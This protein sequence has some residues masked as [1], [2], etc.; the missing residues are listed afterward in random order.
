MNETDKTIPC[1]DLGITGYNPA[2]ELQQKIFEM[3][4]SGKFKGAILLLEHNPVITIG[5]NRNQENILSDKETL[6]RQG[7]ELIQSNRGGDVTFHGPGQLICYPVFDLNHF[8]KDV[9]NFVYNLEQVVIDVLADYKIKGTRIEKLRGVFVGSGKIASIG[10]HVKKWIT[11]HGFSFNVNVD[12]GYFN[13]IIACGLKDYL[14][15]SLE[16]LLTKPVSVSDVKELVIQK[17]E[18][19]FSIEVEERPATFLDHLS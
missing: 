19:I 18:K 11:Y 17:F 8:G 13:N 2:W 5:N 12:L 10:I 14:P 1:F 15:V 6:N 7:I 16:K 3:V 9:G 4:I